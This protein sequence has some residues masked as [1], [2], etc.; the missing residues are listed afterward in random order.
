MIK[1]ILIITAI[2]ILTAIA[3]TMLWQTQRNK[4]PFLSGKSI[5]I[6]T[7]IEADSTGE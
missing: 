3:G 5:P 2:I 6:N 7:L 1:K 4:I